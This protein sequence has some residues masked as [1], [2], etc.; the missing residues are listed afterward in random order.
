MSTV[1]TDQGIVIPVGTDAADNPTAF[2]DMIA[3]VESRLVLRYTDLANRTALHTAPVEGQ[4]TD[5]AAE[6]RMDAYDGATYISAA[7]RGLYARRM[8]T[9]DAAA[10]VNNT[11]VSDATLTVPLDVTG[12]YRFYG[13]IYYDASTV[14]DFK[15]AFTFP[16]VA[17]SGSKWGLLG[18]DATTATNITAA[19]ATAS[20][21][22]IAAGGN[23][24]GTATFA[25]FDG[26]INIT[27]TGNLVTQYAQN[28]TEATNM[29]VRFG[30]YLE[31]IKAG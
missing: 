19:V 29:T 13:R 18:R 20:G 12:L 1:T 25:D 14:A 15:L 4:L 7:A 30:S 27:A 26:F 22:A 5:L 11:L 24:V 17:A 8:R 10:I 6:N 3:G 9:T 2:V 31:V 21:T 28:T 16:A 23:G